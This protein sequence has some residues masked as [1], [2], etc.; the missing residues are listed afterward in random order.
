MGLIMC[1]WKV[2]VLVSITLLFNITYALEYV[3]PNKN[4]MTNNI[5]IPDFRVNNDTTGRCFH[6]DPEVACSNNGRSVI[7]WVDNRN[8]FRDVFFQLYDENGQI[9]GNNTKV[10][11]EYM[12]YPL[13]RL[14]VDMQDNGNFIIA[15]CDMGRNIISF[16]RFDKSGIPIGSNTIANDDDRSKN[17]SDLC[18]AV[19]ST[20][21]FC[22]AWEDDRNGHNN[23][24][25]YQCYDNSGNPV[26]ANKR[27]NDNNTYSYKFSPQIGMA[28]NGNIIITW[29][30]GREWPTSIYSQRLNCNGDSLGGNIKVSCLNDIS[31]SYPSI[32]VFP[33]GSFIVSWGGG[34]DIYYQQYNASGDAFGGNVCNTSHLPG[35]FCL[36]YKV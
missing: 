13:S 20:G 21:R 6:N 3:I 34:D 36:N 35:H 4:S 12:E 27:L 15:W 26:G 8:G 1:R 9:I 19:D 11:E 32:S 2:T 31:S 29:S 16:Q 28:D 25:Y 23:N 18:V 30:D 33:N 14:A 7:A 22:I 10:N 17:K 5:I 24:I